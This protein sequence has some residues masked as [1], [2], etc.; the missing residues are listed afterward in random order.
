[1]RIHINLPEDLV[2]DIDLLAGKGNRSD[3]IAELIRSEI[4]AR[5]VQWAIEK[6]A[7]ILSDE[8]YP[9]FS[10]PEKIAAWFKELRETPSLRKDPIDE[11]LAGLE[12]GDELAQGK[13]ARAKPGKAPRS[14]AVRS[15]T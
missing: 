2:R 8:D 9:H 4:R 14:K 6:G 5:K 3:Y 13:R 11:V 10:T 1:V 12:R 15:R 7:G